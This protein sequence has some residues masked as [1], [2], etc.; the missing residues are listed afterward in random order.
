MNDLLLNSTYV[1]DIR[2]DGVYKNE[3]IRIGQYDYCC[4]IGKE[5]NKD[6]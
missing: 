1:C 5:Y 3:W 6:K 4:Y 2:N